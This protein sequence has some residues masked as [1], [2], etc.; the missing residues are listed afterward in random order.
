MILILVGKSIDFTNMLSSSKFDEINYIYFLKCIDTVKSV[1][2]DASISTS[3]VTDV[4]LVGGSTPIPAL[5]SQLYNLFDGKVELGKSVH[6]G[7]AVAIGAAVQGYILA[8][9]GGGGVEVGKILHF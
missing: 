8:T 9:G 7:E 1:L 3:D 4:I 2:A 5:Q 6:P